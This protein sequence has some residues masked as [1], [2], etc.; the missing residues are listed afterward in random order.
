ML[1]V[2]AKKGPSRVHELGLIAQ[3]HVPRGTPVWRFRPGL[4]ARIPEA[5]YDALPP[6]VRDQVYYYAFFHEPSRSYVLSGDD[7]RFTN[8]SD[9][10]N[11][12][13]AGDHTV[14]VRDLR[15]GDEITIDYGDMAWLSPE[16]LPGACRV[17]IGPCEFGRGLFAAADLARGQPALT[18]DGPL[19]SLAEALAK[20]ETTG[21]PMQVGPFEYVDLLAPSVF[22]NHSCDPNAGVTADRVLVALRDIAFGEEVRYDYSTTMWEDIWTMRCGCGA[23]RCRGVIEDFPLLPA[24]AQA[25]YLRAGVVQPFIV[26]RLR[27]ERLLP[28]GCGLRP[29]F[30]RCS[31]GIGD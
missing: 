9:D 11:T 27:A 18:F 19:I 7:D 24:E 31:K 17:Y 4:D 12:R 8:H 15:P 16:P 13:V 5:E 30:R 20:G 21:N 26:E 25:R 10:P 28:P 3:E 6:P 2:N 22:G 14:L 1:L 29:A 23:A